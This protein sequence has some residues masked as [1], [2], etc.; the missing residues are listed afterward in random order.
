[1]SYNINGHRPRLKMTERVGF[2]KTWHFQVKMYILS[3]TILMT[4]WEVGR[5]HRFK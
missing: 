3:D 5:L 4:D 2:T 1:M